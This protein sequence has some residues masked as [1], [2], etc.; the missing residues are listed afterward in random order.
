MGRPLGLHRGPYG[1]VHRTS[2]GDVLRKSL[3]RNF[4]EWGH[5]EWA[6]VYFLAQL[7]LS[8]HQL[9]HQLLE[10]LV[11]L[12][13]IHLLQHYHDYFQHELLK[14][15]IS[16]W[17]FMKFPFFLFKFYYQLLFFNSCWQSSIVLNVL[18]C[19]ICILLS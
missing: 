4:A 7:S 5:R 10:K 13:V 18:Q 9:A 2:F 17:S 14:M 12:L 6:Q 11:P 16:I 3:G 19:Y 15:S 1:D 8:F